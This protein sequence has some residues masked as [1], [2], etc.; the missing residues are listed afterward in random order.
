MKHL[1][2]CD[3]DIC[4]HQKK[5]IKDI[6]KFISNEIDG[7]K[8]KDSLVKNSETKGCGQM[9]CT[10][11]SCGNIDG[12]HSAYCSDHHRSIHKICGETGVCEDCR[13]LEKS[14]P[15]GCGKEIFTGVPPFKQSCSRPCG[16]DPKQLCD[17]CRKRE[18]HE[19]D[20][21]R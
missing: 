6:F 20:S 19:G 10:V 18:N 3:C 17:E 21:G 5:I 14:E 9:Y 2:P 16:S 4:F 1:Q 8:P 12:T 15:K 13:K 11:E 7:L